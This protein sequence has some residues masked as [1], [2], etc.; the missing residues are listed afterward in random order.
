MLTYPIKH[1][2][3]AHRQDLLTI[4]E[5]Q[6]DVVEV[7]QKLFQFHRLMKTDGVFEYL[8]VVVPKVGQECAQSLF[9][10]S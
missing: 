3:F 10:D 7:A 9:M 5:M 1:E 8:E 2:D 4:D 6:H